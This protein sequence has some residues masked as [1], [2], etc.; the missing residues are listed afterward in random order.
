[1]SNTKTEQNF[2][3]GLTVSAFQEPGPKINSF[4][5]TEASYLEV[6]VGY[7]ISQEFYCTNSYLCLLVF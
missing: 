7:Q 4:K 2:N 5:F 3:P 6:R 1:M